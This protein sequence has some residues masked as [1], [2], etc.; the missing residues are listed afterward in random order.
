[1]ESYVAASSPDNDVVD[2]DGAKRPPILDERKGTAETCEFDFRTADGLAYFGWKDNRVVNVLSNFHGTDKCTV[3]RTQKD[4]TRAEVSCPVAVRDYNAHMGGVD[5]A[6]ML[7]SLYGINR[8]SRKWWHRLFFGVIDR[9]LVN[10]FVVYNKIEEKSMPLLLFRRLVAQHLLTAARPPQIGRP[11]STS[12]PGTPQNPL[13]RRK[14]DYS[15]SA[16]IR[17]TNR[18]VHWPVFVKKRGR[19]EVCSQNKVESRPHSQ[20]S[21]YKVFLCCN[22]KKQC[23]LAYHEVNTQ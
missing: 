5:K 11:L 19:C 23:F 9:M 16:D 10:S 21:T 7:C 12:R 22:E 20:C 18:G 17:L 4:G 13:K 15:V 1:M 8:K 2:V 14:T 3:L 6:D